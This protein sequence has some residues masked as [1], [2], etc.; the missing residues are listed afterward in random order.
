VEMMD[1]LT[2][3]TKGFLVLTMPVTI[4]IKSSSAISLQ[5]VLDLMMVYISYK[6]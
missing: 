6:F 4:A 1:G 2:S 5:V 3:S